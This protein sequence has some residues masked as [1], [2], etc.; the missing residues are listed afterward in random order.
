M[1]TRLLEILVCPACLPREI[2]LELSVFEQQGDDVALGRL[3]CPACG[4]AYPIEDGLASLLPPQGHAPDAQSKYEQP[5]V[6]ASYL[7]S[8]FAD[9]RA[10]PESTAAHE[11]LA[12]MFPQARAENELALDAGCAVGRMAFELAAKGYFAVGLDL[13]RAFAV[14]AR[15]LA[16]LRRLDY[17][18]PVEGE[19]TVGRTVALPERFP[20]GR[21]EFIQASV[22]APPF[23]AGVFAALAS[24]NILDKV[25][26][27]LSHLLELSRLAAPGA[28]LVFADPFSWSEDCAPKHRWLGGTASAT[29]DC[30][31][32]V[33]VGAILSGQGWR[34]D[35]D[36]FVWWKIRNHE[37]H[38]ELIRSLTLRATKQDAS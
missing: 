26:E 34:V 22:L 37:N 18:E 35:R 28:A 13:S 29:Y 4:Q 23:R 31:G 38:Y 8:H 36:G 33:N 25:P 1:L 11:A 19:I 15:D 3:D 6:T 32:I 9:L 16:R 10:A 12:A 27:P 14:A 21:A 30:R 2:G 5:R 24:C 17:D 7:W 20:P